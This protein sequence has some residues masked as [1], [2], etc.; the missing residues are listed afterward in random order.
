MAIKQAF[1]VPVIF[2]GS[3]DAGISCIA[4]TTEGTAANEIVCKDEMTSAIATEAAK[5]VN[6][7]GS[8]GSTAGYATA[9]SVTAASTTQEVPP[10]VEGGDPTTEVVPAVVTIAKDSKDYINISTSGAVTLAFTAAS[11]TQAATKVI[12]LAATAET[13][14]TV[15]GATWANGGDA[16]TWGTADEVL[17]IVATFLA[18]E[19]ILSVVHNSESASASASEV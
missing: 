13:T 9:Q 5:K 19:V 3:L 1:M 2:G 12:R 16:P 15:T 7:S 10:E 17:I 6:V 8:R 14:L 4:G 18:G 11:A